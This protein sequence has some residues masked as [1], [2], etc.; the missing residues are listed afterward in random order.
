MPSMSN[1][2]S[3]V[4][5]VSEAAQILGLS[6]DMVR[7]LDKQGKLQA[8]RLGNRYRVFVRSHVEQLRIA[9]AARKAKARGRRT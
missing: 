5:T 2:I 8:V 3:P 9:R 1:E 6:A 4:V 7:L